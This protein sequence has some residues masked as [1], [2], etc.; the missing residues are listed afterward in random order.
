VKPRM[1]MKKRQSR[2]QSRRDFD[3]LPASS[4]SGYV[5]PA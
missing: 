3:A 1:Q 5:L 4:Q 2:P